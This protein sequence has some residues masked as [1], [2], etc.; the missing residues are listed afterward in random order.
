[1]CII[2]IKPA[3]VSFPDDD[4]ITTMWINNPD[5]A[6]FMYAKDG[7]VH[8]EKGF[9]ELPHLLER[10]AKVRKDID[11]TETPFVL[12]FRITTHGGTKPANCHPF[13]ISENVAVLQK[14][15]MHTDMGVAHNGIIDIRPRADISD[16]MEYIVSQLAVIKSIDKRFLHKRK[17]MRLI[18]NAIGSKMA[19]L[20][21]DGEIKTIG[22]FETAADGMRYSN[23][24]YMP[25]ISYSKWDIATS[26]TTGTPL[27]TTHGGRGVCKQLMLISDSD[28][29]T[30]TVRRGSKLL[31]AFDFAVDA[32]GKLYRVDWETGCAYVDAGCVLDGSVKFV[33]QKASHYDCYPSEE[34]LLVEVYG[35]EEDLPWQPT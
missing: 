1:M 23:T 30:A 7:R 14:L 22:R 17:F 20:T 2:A 24:S 12:H 3:G 26:Y 32:K 34:A 31:D 25:R 13:P 10:L 19:F 9:M 27:T 6:G 35:L 5:G 16:T 18:E 15:V 29:A 4:R 11:A 8:I 21:G 28:S 33:R